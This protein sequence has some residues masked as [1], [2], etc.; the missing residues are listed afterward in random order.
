MMNEAPI[1]NDSTLLLPYDCA[2][3]FTLFM[4]CYSTA[5]LLACGCILVSGCYLCVDYDCN[6]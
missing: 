4:L 3:F 6:D 5:Y 2:T 1:A